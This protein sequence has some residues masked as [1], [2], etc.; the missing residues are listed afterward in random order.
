MLPL[1]QP[2][3]Y[4]ADFQNLR[5]SSLLQRQSHTEVFPPAVLWPC[6]LLLTSLYHISGCTLEQV[7]ARLPGPMWQETLR[8]RGKMLTSPIFGKVVRTSF[9]NSS[10]A[11]R[12]WEWM[13][14][15]LIFS[16]KRSAMSS[17]MAL[18]IVFLPGS[19][20]GPWRRRP[21]FRPGSAEPVSDGAW[22][23]WLQLQE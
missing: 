17:L 5:T 19:W 6:G 11:S 10:A 23:R 20:C 14:S 9:W 4:N 18:V 21:A 2:T 13:T 1:R 16:P 8:E 3:F 12:L 7:S 22:F 15:R